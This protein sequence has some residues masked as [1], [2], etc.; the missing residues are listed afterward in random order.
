MKIQQLKN[1]G[2]RICF[3][4]NHIWFSNKRTKNKMPIQCPH[5][6]NPN[7]YKKKLTRKEKNNIKK[8]N[9]K[10]LKKYLSSK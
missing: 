9:Y 7:W 2:L 10:I 1:K 5:C 8:K 3:K 4:C 6:K